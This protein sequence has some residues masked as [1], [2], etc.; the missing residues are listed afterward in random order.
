MKEAPHGSED[1]RKL[2]PHVFR[3]S[4]KAMAYEHPEVLAAVKPRIRQ[5]KKPLLNKLEQK[6]FEVLKATYPPDC[7]ITA[8]S[9]RFKLANG[10][11]YKPDFICWGR[12]RIHCY[13]VKGPHAFR[14]GFE[15]LKMAKSKYPE[16]EWTLVWQENGM[17]REQEVLA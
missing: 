6:W 13:E 10:L 17:W 4:E 16:F 2:N 14:G 11:W 9:T 3:D 7:L 8:Q 12:A 5:S 15:N 1:F